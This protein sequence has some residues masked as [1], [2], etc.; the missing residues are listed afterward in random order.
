MS[1]SANVCSRSSLY[2][3]H[4][5]RVRDSPH[6][7]MYVLTINIITLWDLT[8]NALKLSLSQITGMSTISSSVVFQQWIRF[9]EKMSCSLNMS[10]HFYTRFGAK[11]DLGF[12]FQG[13]QVL[14]RSCTEGKNSAEHIHG[15][16]SGGVSPSLL[17]R[18]MRR[19]QC[20]LPRN[21]FFS[22][23]GLKLHI[24]VHSPVHLS[25]CFAM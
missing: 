21:V 20:P 17:G 3:Q 11:A 10:G 5:H 13:V 23:L 15:W 14:C 24:L 1:L 7:A 16:V 4:S 9:R 8:K 2:T 22:S 6:M 19:E 25:V 18:H 12:G